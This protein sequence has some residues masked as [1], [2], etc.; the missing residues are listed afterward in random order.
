M[1][2]KE[3]L[4]GPL[5]IAAGIVMAA[6]TGAAAYFTLQVSS[7][8]AADATVDIAMLGLIAS[9]TLLAVFHQG[10]H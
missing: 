9:V 8:I 10:F 7:N 2:R 4:S 6:L 3:G 5:P 1:D